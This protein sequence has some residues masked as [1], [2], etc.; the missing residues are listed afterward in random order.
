MAES[1]AH[2]VTDL[3]VAWRQGDEQA[4][5]RLMPLV[6]AELRRLAR[7][8]MAGERRGHVL[9]ATALVNEA[10]LRL[11]N[12]RQVQWR[13]R[14]H[15]FAMAA[16]LMRRVLVDAA[17]E[18]RAQRRGGGQVLVTFDEDLPVSADPPYD[19]V[20]LDDA[21][22]ALAVDHSRKARV[23]ELRFFGGLSVDQTAHVLDVSDDTMTRDWKFAK[24]WLL[25]EMTAG[26]QGHRA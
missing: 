15:F 19:L 26:Q 6:H 9:Q 1:R 20:A 16:R 7:G 14:A 21:L 17:R 8:Q 25:R 4:L 12:L 18:R 3:L 24:A 10:Y 11:V 2:Q 23:V 5:E 22:Q 13:D